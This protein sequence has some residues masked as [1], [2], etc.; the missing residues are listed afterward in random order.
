MGL[1]VRSYAHQKRF[2]GWFLWPGISIS[3]VLQLQ[4]ITDKFKG[5]KLHE[6]TPLLCNYT[7]DCFSTFTCLGHVYK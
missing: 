1:Y 5:Y 7:K 4:V 6:K 3:I 2:A